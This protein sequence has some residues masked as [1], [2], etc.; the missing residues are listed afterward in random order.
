MNKLDTKHRS[1]VAQK[2]RPRSAGRSPRR[3]VAVGRVEYRP[4]WHTLLLSKELRLEVECTR[5]KVQPV[6]DALKGSE[7]RMFGGRGVAV[8]AH[9]TR[10]R[11]GTQ[12]GELD[13]TVLTGVV[14]L[15]EPVSVTQMCL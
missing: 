13:K 12:S 14:P 4:D 10:V 15:D 2:V 6:L 9:N 1:Q 5:E 8:A 11:R 3:P 7:R